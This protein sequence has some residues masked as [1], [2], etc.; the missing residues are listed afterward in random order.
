MSCI[1]AEVTCR[2]QQISACSVGV[3]VSAF[4]KYTQ[5]RER[6]V[7]AICEIL[8]WPESLELVK[9]VAAEDGFGVGAALIAAI[10][11]NN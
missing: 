8:D 9:L 1:L 10:I 3:D 11:L 7:A 2:K 5:F 4:E 6:A